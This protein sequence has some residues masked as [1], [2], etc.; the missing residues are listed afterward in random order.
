MERKHYPVAVLILTIVAIASMALGSLVATPAETT[1]A[2]HLL[3]A[4]GISTDQYMDHV[5]FLADPAMEGRGNGSPALDDA[6]EYLA[7]QFRLW[8][9]RPAGENGTY[10]QTFELTT[11]TELGPAS[12]LTLGQRQLLPG[13][14][15]QSVRFSSPAT[16]GASLVFVGYGITAPEMHWD[17]YAGVDVT[18]K[19]VVVFRHEP[20]EQD[21]DSPFDGAAFTSHAS[22][23]NKA[24]NARQ[25]GA[26]GIVF[27]LD[28]NNHGADEE[29]IAAT[30]TGTATD[31]SGIAAAYARM[32][33]VLS[34]FEAGGFDL[35]QM[36]SEIDSQLESRSFEFAAGTANLT[37]DIVRIRKPVR[38]VL[39]AIDGSD[40]ELKN[41]WII[42]GAHYDHL[43][44]D[45]EFSLARDGDG[46]IHHGADDNA[47]GTAGILELARIAGRNRNSFSRSLLLMAF[48]GEEVGLRG[49]SHFV[50]EPTIDI[51]NAV[52]MLNLDMIGRL[53]D[54]HV[55]V[56]GV[57]TSPDFMEAL[58]QVSEPIG[59]S[60]DYSDSGMGASDHMS[61]NIKKIPV[62]FFFSGLHSDYHRPSDTADKINADGA[63]KVLML[64]YQMLGRLAGPVERPL[65]TEVSEPRPVTGSGGG[66]GPYFGSIPDFRDD[67]GGVLF[68]D[69]SPASPAD[70]AG[71]RAGDLMVE[72]NGKQIQNLYDFTYALQAETPGNTVTVVVERDGEPV[73]AEVTLGTR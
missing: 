16:V 6:A 37:T 55:Y 8:G 58:E 72:F 17:D 20:Q 42:A 65:Y 33:P 61:F 25:H 1:P 69:I 14:E 62:L 56:S 27:I 7:A 10:F 31:D 45:G 49:S 41:E 13:D 34:Y 60:L 46:Q 24:I 36:Q 52:A 44:L 38:N 64:A 39:A 26:A 19:I 11:G 35:R 32:E 21:E 43:G 12:Q 67:L 2:S 73:A 54:D 18:G 70:D 23:M 57:G 4:G 51:E 15:F 71:F 30:A 5:R 3:A 9:L 53:R 22:L 29:A 48:A 66:Y 47:S 63:R 50:A 40:P 28:P 68:A 59:L